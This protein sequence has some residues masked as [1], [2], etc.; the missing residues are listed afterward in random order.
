[1]RRFLSIAAGLV[2]LTAICTDVD[3]RREPVKEE[4]AYI[5]KPFQEINFFATVDQVAF[6]EISALDG[7]AH[8]FCNPYQWHT[9]PPFYGQWGAI[10]VQNATPFYMYGAGGSPDFCSYCPPLPC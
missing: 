6:V 2:A 3:A 9:E 7:M 8:C 4:M 10:C 1:M 5:L